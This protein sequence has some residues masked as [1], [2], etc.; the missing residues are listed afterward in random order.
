MVMWLGKHTEKLRIVTCGFVSTTNNPLATAEKIATM[1]HMLN[2]RFGVGLV[3]GYQARWV[4]NYKVQPALKA[5]GPWNKN[6]NEDEF[7]RRYFSE[8]VEI[9]ISALKNETFSYQG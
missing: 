2:G 6:T 3:R 1:D 5:V 9:V 4:E 7:N 8:F